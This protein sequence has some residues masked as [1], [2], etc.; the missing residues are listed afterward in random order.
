M[1]WG[2]F[3]YLERR[4]QSNKEID[5]YWNMQKTKGAKLFKKKKKKEAMAKISRKKNR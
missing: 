3:E 5:D 4:R 1:Y 2:D